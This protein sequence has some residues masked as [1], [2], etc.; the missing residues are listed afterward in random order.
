MTII[1]I[2]SLFTR[3]L[4][5]SDPNHCITMVSFLEQVDKLANNLKEESLDQL[6]QCPVL[7]LV[8]TMWKG[9]LLD[10]HQSIEI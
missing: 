7:A 4:E 9:F 1:S 2:N 10:L 6:L 8:M 5:T 3:K